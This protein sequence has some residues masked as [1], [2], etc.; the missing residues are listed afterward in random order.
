[1]FG[2]DWQTRWDDTIGYLNAKCATDRLGDHIE[3]VVPLNKR[4]T[5]S[6][7]IS[8]GRRSDGED[9]PEY[10]ANTS[11][12]KALRALLLCQRV[13]YFGDTWAKMSEAGPG[14]HVVPLNGLMEAG[15]KT[16]SLQFWR[17]KSED[18]ILQ[19]IKMF[20][21]VEGASRDD[22]ADIAFA[23]AP[24]GTALPGNLTLS[25]TDNETYGFGV[26][27]YVGVQGWL[28]RSGLVSMRWLMLN[29]APN[30]EVGC[31]LLFG[32][33]E[34][35]WNG[36]LK[37]GDALRVRGLIQ[38]IPRGSIVHIYSPDNFNWNGHWVITNGDGTICGVNN[39]EFEADEAEKGKAV[40]KNYTNTST[41]FEQFW[42]YG[43]ENES[44]GKKT[45][46]MV[47][48]NPL[49]MPRL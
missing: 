11:Q 34:T 42:S 28:V 9:D 48:I 26:I 35:L 49:E 15:W 40:Q 14:L 24:N 43:G 29:S 12:R 30:K 33:G 20:V 39:G 25:R 41:L 17:L 10:A 18:Q 47:V 36:K 45:A 7:E 46:V 32:E 13:Y 6:G 16:E 8:L 22:L 19:G 1:M 23:G 37:P 38:G 5:L 44:A 27:C 21:P 3:S 4:K 31:N 2:K